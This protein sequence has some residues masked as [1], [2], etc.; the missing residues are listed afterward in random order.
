MRSGERATE[1]EPIVSTQPDADPLI[2]A[3]RAALRDRDFARARTALEAATEAG[4]AAWALLAE[5]YRQQGAFDLEEQAV[6][7]L[8]ERDTRDLTGLVMKGDCLVRQGKDRAASAFYA[9]ALRVGGA[10]PQSR[11]LLDRAQRAMTDLKVRFRLHIDTRLADA[12]F[13]P[14]SRPPRFQHAIDLMEG[15][16]TREDGRFDRYPQQPTTFFYPGLPLRDFFERDEFEWVPAL[17]AAAPAMRAELEAVLADDA[18]FR[19]YM[20]AGGAG[21]TN[22]HVL[23]GDPS[24]SAFYLCKDGAWVEPNASRCPRTV[25]ALSHVPLPWV[26]GRSPNVLFSLLRPGAHIPPHTGILNTQL[27]GHVPLITPPGCTLRVGARAREWQDGQAMIFDDSIE[28]EAW[29]RASST[30]VV[31]LFDIWRP[32][33][34]ADERSAVATLLGAIEDYGS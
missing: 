26:A 7:R 20:E 24:W 5:V 6:D 27:I 19:P 12:G 17:E 31:L 23:V 22:H 3:G 29:N 18:A 33:L 30:R 14:G 21:P 8:L 32:E 28:H 15:R 4:G 2:E 9:A 16:R 34:S 10:A 11:A 25:E 1:E 13:A